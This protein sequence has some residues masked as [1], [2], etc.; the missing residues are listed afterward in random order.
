LW[1][2]GVAG[3]FHLETQWIRGVTPAMEL[4]VDST[5]APSGSCSGPVESDL[6]YNVSGRLAV[7]YLPTGVIP[8]NS[9]MSLPAAVCCD[10]NQPYPEPNGFFARPDVALFSH[11][12]ASSGV[13]TFYDSVC[14]VPVFQA[15]MGRTFAEWQAETE[16]HGWPSFRSEEVVKDNIVVST[17]GTVTSKCGTALGSYLPDSQGDRFCIDLVCISGNPQ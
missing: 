11:I 16:E 9:D 8:D 10:P 4:V 3:N 17:S 5:D 2:E 13:T 15:P 7:D 1:A 12:N 6:K 14:G